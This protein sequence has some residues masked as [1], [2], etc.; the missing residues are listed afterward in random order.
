MDELKNL[1]IFETGWKIPNN[2]KFIKMQAFSDIIDKHLKNTK[3]S[4]ETDL[5]PNLGI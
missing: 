2:K 5:H 3:K 1:N 4:I